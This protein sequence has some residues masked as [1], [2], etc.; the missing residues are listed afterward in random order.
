M[1]SPNPFDITFITVNDLPQAWYEVTKACLLKGHD[2]PVLLGARKE[3]SRK[4]LACLVLRVKR[5][6]ETPLIPD[7][8]PDKV[9]LPTDM[10][11]VYK[12]LNY[13]ATPHKED[14]EDYTYGERTYEMISEDKHKCDVQESK[15]IHGSGVPQFEK[16]VEFLKRA[17]ETNR[18]IVMVGKAQDLLLEHPPCL[19]LMHFKVYD[20]RLH[21][22]L[23]FRS[24]DT[25]AG[26][27]CNLAGYQLFKQSLL[28]T[29][30]DHYIEHGLKPIRDGEIIASSMGAHIYSGCFA[31][32]SVLTGEF[33]TVPEAKKKYPFVMPNE[34]S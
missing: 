2:R 24:W 9:P 13:I 28:N 14:S 3:Q 34:I 6:W 33:K 16:M 22:Y 5:P 17:P 12:Y 19:R 8:A 4:E 26:L 29:L 18:G 1:S 11:Y 30:N 10:N 7:H 25:Y 32:V 20:G 21:L 23:Y 15:N 31:F 27:P